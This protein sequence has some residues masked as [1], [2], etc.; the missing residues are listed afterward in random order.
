MAIHES[1][2]LLNQP[3]E[4]IKH[5]YPHNWRS[6]TPVIF[7]ATDQWFI[8][9]DHNG[10]RKK[11]LSEI[12]KTAW[13]PPWGE[14]RI[15]GMIEKRP[16]WV[17]SRQRLW[18]VPIPTFSCQDC[19]S[20]TADADFMD[21]VAAVFDEKGADAWYEDGG[22]GLIPPETKCSHCGSKNIVLD[23]S[24]VDVWFESGCSWLA[25]CEEREE[26]CHADLYLEGS[27]Q[28][29]GWFHSSLLVSIG[30]AEKAP[31]KSVL[32][33]GF[34]L[35]DNGVPYS[36]SAIEK[37]KKA[38]KKSKYIPPDD[39]IGKFGAEILRLW[40][41]STEF[42]ND[43]PYSQTILTGLSDFYRKFRN[44]SRF[45]LGNL[46]DFDPNKITK[47]TVQLNTIDQYALAKL[48]H[49][50]FT[51]KNAYDNFQFHHVYKAMADYL[52]TEV[53][54]FYL[55]VTKDRLYCDKPDSARRQA[56][57]YVLYQIG[58]SLT[59]VA[60]PILCFTAEDIWDHLPKTEGA[61]NSVH[62]TTMPSGQS[63]DEDGDMQKRWSMLFGYRD[64]VASPL[65][66]FRAQ[67]NRAEQAVVTISPKPEDHKA[68]EEL[69]ETLKD[70]L[71]VSEII[72]SPP[73]ASK[74][75][76]V[77]IKKSEHNHCERCRLYFKTLAKQPED[78]CNR[79][80]EALAAS[81]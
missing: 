54:S 16:D 32:T 21:H 18:G 59:K 55:D 35:D 20:S 4:S 8:S 49:F 61:P 10:L 74:T 43:I 17:L 34:V 40:V 78:V 12:E 69:Q 75:S 22:K 63:M 62:L 30:V 27:D 2:H 72:V 52:S 29:R 73:N 68:L 13:I 79:C 80:S 6:K 77:S 7:R 64:L 44:T 5:S 23:D 60:A 76:S 9:V 28:H 37:A 53:S 57:Q 81:P 65:E 39:V 67:K 46:G 36:K 15:N 58:V 1:G 42:R 19:E 50:V 11:A 24:I 25:V 3:G 47:D 51:V 45:I 41:S 14:N 26:L 33:H 38:G 71:L 70:V 66:E 48:D 56:A 31:Y